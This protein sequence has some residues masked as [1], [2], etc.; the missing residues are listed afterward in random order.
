MYSA[1][2]PHAI[3][4]TGLTYRKTFYQLN[5]TAFHGGI[6]SR[7]VKSNQGITPADIGFQ[8]GIELTNMVI[9]IQYDFGIHDALKYK[10]PSHSFEIS[11]SLYGEA[12]ETETLMLPRF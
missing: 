8:L 9:G 11:L 10:A 6:S 4:L 12:Q 7:L 2:G 3:I 5:E 1:Q